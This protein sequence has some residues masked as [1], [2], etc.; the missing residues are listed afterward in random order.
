MLIQPSRWLAVMK[1]DMDSV[2]L[3]R[4]HPG[5]LAL[6]RLRD[7]GMW[8]LYPWLLTELA[9][10]LQPDAM[11]LQP[12]IFR[13]LVYVPCWVL[14]LWLCSRGGLIGLKSLRRGRDPLPSI[15]AVGLTL[16]TWSMFLGK[17]STSSHLFQFVTTD[18]L[19]R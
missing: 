4:K 14:G 16:F 19:L 9:L 17:L 1:G 12:L 13:V 6:L 11:A 10:P 15:L 2:L 18:W 8:I 3:Q 7:A 5:R